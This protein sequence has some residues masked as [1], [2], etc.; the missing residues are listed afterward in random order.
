MANL[1]GAVGAASVWVALN[2]IYM[3]IGLPL[4]HRR[5]LK[6]EAWRWLG[7]IGLPLVAVLL[8][9]LIGRGLV[10]T[11]MSIPVGICGLLVL[12]FSATGAAAFVS[13]T[14][15]PWLVSQILRAGILC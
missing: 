2:C 5:L 13:P 7:D 3:V 8:I 12:L 11:S 9:V 4:T 6:G 10:A 14:I 15:R 1:Y